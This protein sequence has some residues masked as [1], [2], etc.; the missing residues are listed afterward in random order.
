MHSPCTPSNAA[1]ATEKHQTT[2]ADPM[3]RPAAGPGWYESTWELHSGLE[4]IEV[5]NAEADGR[6]RVA[7]VEWLSA[8]A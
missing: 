7:S 5:L 6:R 2:C 8:R 3:P 4:V 1:P